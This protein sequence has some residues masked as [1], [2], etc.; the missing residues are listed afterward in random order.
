MQRGTGEYL[1]FTHLE[2]ARI[3]AEL[4]VQWSDGSREIVVPPFPINRRSIL[5]NN[6]NKWKV[7]LPIVK[8]RIIDLLKKQGNDRLNQIS[9]ASFTLKAT[10]SSGGTSRDSELVLLPLDSIS[11]K[12][13]R[14]SRKR[15]S[16]LNLQLMTSTKNPRVG[17][18][19]ILHVRS[20]H[21]VDDFHC[22]IIS[23]IT[24]R[25][26]TTRQVSMGDYL[27]LKTFDE[28]ITLEM[29]PSATFIVWH[30][31]DSSGAIVYATLTVQISSRQFTRVRAHSVMSGNDGYSEILL[32]G[33]PQSTVAFSSKLPS[34][35]WEDGRK[36]SYNRH[37][38]D[39]MSK[40]FNRD[41][42]IKQDMVFLTDGSNFQ[43]NIN[44]P[45]R[46]N[47]LNL[48]ASQPHYCQLINSRNELENLSVE[49]EFVEETRVCDSRC[50]CNDCS[51]EN[52]VF[53]GKGNYYKR[54]LDKK[55][56]GI[57]ATPTLEELSRS[58]F[59]K[60]VK[61]P[62]NGSISF[63]VPFMGGPHK[64]LELNSISVRS[65]GLAI[66]PSKLVSV[67]AYFHSKLELPPY[68]KLGEH[69][70]VKLTCINYGSQTI[71]RTFEFISSDQFHFLS[72]DGIELHQKV[73]KSI[74]I[75]VDGNGGHSVI[76]LPIKPIKV[77][78]LVVVARLGSSADYLEAETTVDKEGARVDKFSVLN[79]D[80]TNRPYF[81]GT[82]VTN[83]NSGGS[84]YEVTKKAFDGDFFET[85]VT[86][87][88]GVI[89]PNLSR[90]FEN[91]QNTTESDTPDKISIDS[92]LGK[93]EITADEAIFSLVMILHQ[94]EFSKTKSER[95][96]NKRYK[97]NKDASTYGNNFSNSIS[98]DHSM[99]NIGDDITKAFQRL[100]SFQAND[101]SFS[102]THWK[103]RT[104]T[105]S[106]FLTA[107]ALSAIYKIYS[108]NS[109]H[110]RRGH[111]ND[112]L[113]LTVDARIIERCLHWLFIH[114]VSI[115]N[116]SYDL[117]WIFN[118]IIHLHDLFCYP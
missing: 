46:N 53:C 69:V 52:E 104:S 91:F 109:N 12:N 9:P 47:G 14:I 78:K 5:E 75:Q 25:V 51:D 87:T 23:T 33:E 41:F 76:Q 98:H 54:L 61:I 79:V 39:T 32:S 77:G 105:S 108:Y 114:Q 45:S 84:G 57:S 29:A 34:Y 100:I 4:I 27:S 2:G 82:I 110:G 72:H 88:G 93:P 28:F 65:R 96:P 58:G 36:R 16:N 94:K 40:T 66:L 112:K 11:P 26:L 7:N 115:Q 111:E 102:F 60:I 80:M 97:K 73:S 3:I 117:F 22:V 30:V 6:K 70:S 48:K 103:N 20:N 59:W 107:S 99:N 118:S 106:T 74:D 68:V 113:P 50:D 55:I 101:G 37:E 24:N 44:S 83:Q 43:P 1:S 56:Y 85:E 31:D 63:R 42:S 92:I 10:F 21:F 64:Q 15:T 8:K 19:I 49:S 81:I 95:Q 38:V 116:N 86:I 62:S 89:G 90:Y 13:S 35:S 71:F 17:E 67:G 18:S